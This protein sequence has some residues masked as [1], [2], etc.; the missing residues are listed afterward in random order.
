MQL[1]EV[2]F[3]YGGR[4]GNKSGN[5]IYAPFDNDLL[6]SGSTLAQA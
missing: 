2:H 4:A 5:P 1:G 6:S 3:C